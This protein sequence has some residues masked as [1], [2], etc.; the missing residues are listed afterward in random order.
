MECEMKTKEER[1]M[2]WEETIDWARKQLAEVAG[3]LMT[4]EPNQ[5]APC[6]KQGEVDNAELDRIDRLTLETMHRLVDEVC[7][8]LIGKTWAVMRQNSAPS[9]L[10][11]W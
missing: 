11:S 4:F 2:Q 7:L 10:R 9:H 5:D 1:Q 6:Y 3:E 8:I